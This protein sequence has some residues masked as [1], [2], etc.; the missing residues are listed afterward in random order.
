MKRLLL[1]FA[2]LVAGVA[3]GDTPVSTTACSGTSPS[4]S[5]CTA[6]AN[7]QCSCA[8]ATSSSSGGV[9]SGFFT[10]FWKLADTSDSIGSTTLTNSATPVTFVAGLVGNAGNFVRA[11]SENLSAAPSYTGTSFTGSCWINTTLAGANA[12]AFVWI[13]GDTSGVRLVLNTAGKIEFWTNA[14]AAPKATSVASLNDGSWHH[15]VFYHD[16]TAHTNTLVV[17]NG[18]P[19][20]AAAAGEFLAGAGS[21]TIGS[22]GAAQFWNG[23]I[24]A[25]GVADG[26]TPTAAQITALYNAG[27]G[28][29]PP[30]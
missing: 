15:I 24:D 28:V 3:A 14:A 8:A 17:D 10:S 19:V 12:G 2:L 27:A 13:A 6:T 29:E 20:V 26:K 25:C 21:L 23:K 7:I 1:A 9:L 11:S 30:F 18:T 4:Q 16:G 22:T 5:E